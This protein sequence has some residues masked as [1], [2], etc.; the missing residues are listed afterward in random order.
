MLPA[1]SL[2]LAQALKFPM[3]LEQSPF[4]IDRTPEAA[5]YKYATA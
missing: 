3:G 1:L 2:F 4:A 5:P